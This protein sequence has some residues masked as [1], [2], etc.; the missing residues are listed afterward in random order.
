MVFGIQHIVHYGI[1]YCNTWYEVHSAWHISIK[2]LHMKK[3]IITERLTFFGPKGAQQLGPASKCCCGEVLR[4]M[5]PRIVCWATSLH[6]SLVQQIRDIVPAQAFENVYLTSV[7]ATESF[8]HY[9]LD[10]CAAKKCRSLH[11]KVLRV[12]RSLPANPC[13]LLGLQA[14]GS[15]SEGMQA[16][17][18]LGILFQDG[19]QA[20]GRKLTGGPRTAA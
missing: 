6:T 12:V 3:S 11:S 9:L 1:Y 19:P 8:A 15:S 16:P 5:G 10:A 4:E 14:M 7:L 18:T 17:Q 20:N 13:T 2:M